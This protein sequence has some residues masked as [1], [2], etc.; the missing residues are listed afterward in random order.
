[1][2]VILSYALVVAAM[3]LLVLGLVSDDG[4]TLIYLSIAASAAAAL[5][6]VV[7]LR[8]NRSRP[9]DPPARRP[10]PAADAAEPVPQPE[11]ATQPTGDRGQDPGGDVEFPIADYD[12][13]TVQQILPLLP[14]LYDD[15]I[16]VV[17]ERERRTKSRPPVLARLA[18]LRAASVD[19]DDG[20]FPIEDYESLSEAQ[21]QPLLAQLDD[22][23][24]ALVRVREQSLGGRERLL[25]EIDQRLG[26]EGH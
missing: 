10:A 24:L 21:I 17:E 5:V 9:A 8:R 11:D 2:L 14:Q 13:L 26:A 15:E 6:L 12:T 23:E 18:Q 19:D 25:A 4:L 22:E 20:W 3:V 1:M 16:A 7:L